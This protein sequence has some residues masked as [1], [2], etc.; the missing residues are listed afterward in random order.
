MFSFHK[1]KV[2]RST[3]GCCICKAKSSSSRF[4]DSKKYETDFIECFQL[5][6]PRK[7][8]ICNACVLLVKRF[9]RL[10]PGSERHWG[11]VVDARV[12]PGLKSMTKFKKRKE[13]SLQQQ[14]EQRI[15][16]TKIDGMGTAQRF[17]KIFKKNKKKK[18][19]N[20]KNANGT[21]SH[22]SSDDVSS[23]SSP[24]S[25]GSDGEENLKAR[26]GTVIGRSFDN[27]KNFVTDEFT[28]GYMEANIGRR[29]LLR[30][31]YFPV[32]NLKAQI[33]GILDDIQNDE[34]WAK[35]QM[36]CGPV[37]ENKNLSAIIVDVTT[38]KICKFHQEEKITGVTSTVQISGNL[39]A[40]TMKKQHLFTKTRPN[41]LDFV[42]LTSNLGQAKSIEDAKY[43]QLSC[44]TIAPSANVLNKLRDIGKVA[45][46]K[47]SNF[48]KNIVKLCNETKM[49]SKAMTLEKILSATEN[50]GNKF[51]DNSSDSGY[52][53][54]PNLDPRNA[55]ITPNTPKGGIII[56]M[57]QITLPQ[58]QA[59]SSTA[60]K[61]SSPGRL[62]TDR[63]ETVI[64][65]RT[66]L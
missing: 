44:P 38:I 48:M 14:K 63:V 27:L 42:T 52:E 60:F 19:M 12:G 17:C 64:Y 62:H 18:T 28:N 65:A 59:I 7:G 5:T 16:D 37:F 3:Q 36:C 29:T 4:T 6:S 61:R 11:H 57:N 22:G 25:Y 20:E 21:G 31:N 49:P 30:K 53:E 50:L 9:K 43:S 39:G 55:M 15:K 66:G 47:D 51:S 54:L 24:L 8:E 32:K 35:K 56:G 26:K 10:P 34:T 23:P 46:T 2:Y 45:K 13:E 41:I 40:V 1:P 33:E 58:T